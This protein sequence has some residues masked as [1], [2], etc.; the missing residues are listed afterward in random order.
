MEKARR[1]ALETIATFVA[2]S[3]ERE[4]LLA[5]IVSGKKDVLA[6]LRAQT[7]YAL[8]PDGAAEAVAKSAPACSPGLAFITKIFS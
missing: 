3:Q 8:I 7:D 6:S 1:E 5:D 4:K 2:A